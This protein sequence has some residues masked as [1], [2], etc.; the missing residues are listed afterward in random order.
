MKTVTIDE[1][2][3]WAFVHEL[4]KGGGVEGL[5][6]NGSAWS[7]ICDLGVRID[8]GSTGSMFGGDPNFLIEQGEPNEDAVTAGRAVA[9]LGKRDIVLPTGWNPL[10]DWPDTGGL[11]EQAVARAVDR[12]QKRGQE[13]RGSEMVALVI[14]TAVLGK[15]PDTTSEPSRVRMVER[16]GKPAWFMK[17]TL[18][19]SL[20]RDHIVEI[21]GFNARAGRPHRNA[22]RRDEL[23]TDPMGDILA[24]LDHQIL[25]AV[26]RTLQ[27]ELRDRMVGHRIA[28]G[29]WSATPWREREDSC[30]ATVTADVSQGSKKSAR[31]A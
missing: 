30:V 17:K 9:D 4:P 16:N 22:Y 8:R 6:N 19:D 26:F 29:D 5:V 7:R 28:P 20:G 15:M 2:L 14:G 31:A 24:R 25:I 11:A 12:V 21:D 3:Q 27:V 13:R 10:S 1:L 23:S 18:T